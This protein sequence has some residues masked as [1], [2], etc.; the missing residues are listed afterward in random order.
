L[1]G[2]KG[3]LSKIVEKGL[4]LW[5]KSKCNRIEELSIDIN[6]SNSSILK[7]KISNM[8]IKGKNIN[9]QEI[10][11]N[12]LEIRVNH[13]K[14]K[15]DSFLKINLKSPFKIYI[16]VKLSG[17]CLKET[18]LSNRWEY[19]SNLICK[20]FFEMANIQDLKVNDSILEIKASN[21]S[22]QISNKKILTIS[23][24]SN[25]LMLT[26]RTSPNSLV[27]PMDE[28]IKIS[29]AYIKKGLIVIHGEA[30]INP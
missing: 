5:I 6:S 20:E 24:K 3:N 21:H 7:G 18:L 17:D 26:E 11:I 25:S 23:E 30:I 10:V 8:H 9:F 28:S 2:S 15:F 4:I 12:I 27:L 22:N 14:I 1:T 29:K 13:I 19:I 16:S